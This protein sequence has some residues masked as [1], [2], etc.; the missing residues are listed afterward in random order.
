MRGRGGVRRGPLR[1][2]GS[3]VRTLIKRFLTDRSGATAIEYA[4]II[5]FLSIIIAAAITSLGTNMYGVIGNATSAL[6]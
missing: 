5:S 2:E 3:S 4:L 1:I 6:H